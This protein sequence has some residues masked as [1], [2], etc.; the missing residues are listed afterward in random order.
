MGLALKSVENAQISL[1]L[2]QIG[3]F[4]FALLEF[5]RH[6]AVQL[7]VEK[8]KVDILILP[9]GVQMILIPH[10]GKVFS[11]SQD[12]IFDI[13]NDGV[14]NHFFIYVLTVTDIQFFYVDIV[15]QVFVLKSADRLKRL[16]PCRDRPHE[17]VR[18]AAL[19]MII[20]SGNTL[21]QLFNGIVLFGTVPDIETPFPSVLHL[22]KNGSMPRKANA[23]KLRRGK[24]L[25]FRHLQMPNFGI[26]RFSTFG[27]CK[28][29]IGRLLYQGCGC[30]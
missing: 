9:E 16:L 21:L 4:E 7:P 30:S 1:E 3:C 25:G 22:F 24:A 17:V 19:M 10:E 20:V 13:M 2:A 14:F 28:C 8:Q 23:E 29:Q 27:T 12:E 18:K 11:E 6:E 26:R 5:N 15:Q